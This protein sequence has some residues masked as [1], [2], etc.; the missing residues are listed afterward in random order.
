MA[1]HSRKAMRSDEIMSC[2]TV[3]K[4]EDVNREDARSLEEPK[5]Y[6]YLCFVAARIQLSQFAFRLEIL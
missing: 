4:L 6:Y 2:E 5:V 3:D 1:C